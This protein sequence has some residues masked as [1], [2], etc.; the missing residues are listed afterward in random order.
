MDVADNLLDDCTLEEARTK[1]KDYLISF[2]FKDNLKGQSKEDILLIKAN[3]VV[4]D[5]IDIQGI[6]NNLNMSVDAQ[7]QFT[8]N[9]G[10]DDVIRGSILDKNGMIAV[11]I[12]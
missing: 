12:Y 4:R 5:K 10:G 3:F 8:K 6:L 1:L 7:N 11:R 9:I 2:G